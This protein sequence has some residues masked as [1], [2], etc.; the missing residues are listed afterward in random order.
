MIDE[1]RYR[2][3]DYPFW[4]AELA[5]RMGIDIQDINT[6]DLHGWLY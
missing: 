1:L 3:E 2:R 4:I 6:D 5:I